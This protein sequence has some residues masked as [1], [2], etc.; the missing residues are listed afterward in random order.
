MSGVCVIFVFICVEEKGKDEDVLKNMCD[1]FVLESMVC[2][3][4]L[5]EFVVVVGDF[6]VDF[7]GYLWFVIFFKKDCGSGWIGWVI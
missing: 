4:V 1:W 6:C 7:V 2:S 3:Y 5:D